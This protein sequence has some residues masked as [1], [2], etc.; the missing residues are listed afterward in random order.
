[1][2][3]RRSALPC[4][5]TTIFLCL[6][7]V[8]VCADEPDQEQWVTLF[9]GRDL[10]GWTPKITGYK[11]GDNFADTFRVRDGAIAVD[12]QGYDQFNGRFGHLFYERSFSHYRL[13]LEY[14]FLGDQVPGGPGWA[15]RNSGVMF[16]C[17]DPKTMRIDQEFPV[18]LEAQVLGGDG[19]NP[20]TTGNVCTPGTHMHLDG[21]R[22]TRH[23]TSA[24]SETFHG[25]QWVELEIEVHGDRLVRHKINGQTVLE[26]TQL[27]LDP[28]D[29]DAK[30]LLDDGAPLALSAGRFALQSESH[31]VEFRN[32]RIIEL[33][34]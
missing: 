12:Y 31:P 32:I 3:T 21:E 2:P 7:C 34:D 19:Q 17:P 8:A 20:R 26:Y 25:P 11:L 15:V 29:P 23:C 16:H 27:E 22:I 14:R 18:S 33:A 1:M 9:N 10:T 6:S 28:S 24:K 4:S 13:K 5:F 30:R